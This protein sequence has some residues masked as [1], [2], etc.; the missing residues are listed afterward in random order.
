[1]LVHDDGTR[2]AVIAS[3]ASEQLTVKPALGASA[4]GPLPTGLTPLGET[5]MVDGVTLDP[6]GIE[7][8]KIN[9]S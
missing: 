4:D 1:M 9:E 3:H 5:C 2:F 7:V 8:F 6:F